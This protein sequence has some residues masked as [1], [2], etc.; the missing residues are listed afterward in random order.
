[1]KEGTTEVTKHKVLI[2][3]CHTRWAQCHTAFHHL[4]QAYMDAQQI[5]KS[6]MDFDFIDFLLT[7]CQYLS[8]MSGR[9]VDII[10]AY[11]MVSM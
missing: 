6:I 10:N 5:Y 7:V 11:S 8:C 9:V 1:M 4:Y 2:D 3:P